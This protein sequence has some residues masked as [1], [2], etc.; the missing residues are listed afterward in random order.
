MYIKQ[1]KQQGFKKFKRPHH[2]NW[3]DEGYF[4]VCGLEQNYNESEFME[5]FGFMEEG[6]CLEEIME[7]D[8][9]GK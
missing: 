9:V 4:S 8:W 7:D 1:L 2:K 3:L 5:V 6:F